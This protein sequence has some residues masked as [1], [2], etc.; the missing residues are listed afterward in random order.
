V[1]SLLGAKEG[2]NIQ[3]SV[4]RKHCRK[5]LGRRCREPKPNGKGIAMGDRRRGQCAS[6]VVVVGSV[7]DQS[8][9][10]FQLAAPCRA[11]VKHPGTRKAGAHQISCCGSSDCCGQSAASLL[12]GR[13]SHCLGPRHDSSGSLQSNGR[14]AETSLECVHLYPS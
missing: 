2:R 1:T 7:Y 14:E 6:S 9:L 10:H 11:Q 12:I 13:N 5:A 8:M 3:L 4:T